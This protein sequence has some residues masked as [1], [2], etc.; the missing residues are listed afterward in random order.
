MKTVKKHTKSDLKRLRKE[1][2]PLSCRSRIFHWH[3]SKEIITQKL[4]K[5]DYVFAPRGSAGV[6][7]LKSEAEPD[8]QPPTWIA[9][10]LP[11]VRAADAWA[12]LPRAC[13]A[14]DKDVHR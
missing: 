12:A 14:L 7:T 8:L 2:K 5:R 1:C 13:R 4:H 6:A 11:E 10:W 3:F 9:S